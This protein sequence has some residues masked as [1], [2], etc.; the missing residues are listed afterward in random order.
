M[1]FKKKIPINQD[2]TL[3]KKIKALSNERAKAASSIGEK[4][5]R[6]II[7]NGTIDLYPEGADK[8]A[9]KKE[10]E[11][12]KYSLSCAIG[13]YDDLCRQIREALKEQGERNTTFG[14]GKNFPTSQFWV[15]LAY[16]DFFKKN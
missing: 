4:T 11:Q 9:A 3:D 6:V 12:A 2:T 1:F 16:E 13:H 7:C 5:K 15:K 10:A 8:E 14:F